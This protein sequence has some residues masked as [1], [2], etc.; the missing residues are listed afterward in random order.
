MEFEGGQESVALDGDVQRWEVRRAISRLKNGK[1]AG[2]DGVVAE[3]LRRGG[4][5]MGESVWWLCWLVFRGEKVPVEWLRAVKVPVRKKGSGTDFEHYRGVTLLSVVGKVFGMVVEA[6]LRAFCESRGILSDAQFGF[7]AGRACRDALMVL[8]EVVERRGGERVFAGF[9]DIAKAYPS[10]WRNGLW[11]K[12][13]EVGVRG[14]MWR[15]LRTLYSKCE[16]AVRVG[17][18]ADDWYEEFVGVREGCVVSP[19][20]FA[21][22]I[23]GLPALLDEGGG[24]SVKVGGTVIR[25]LM[26]ADDVVMLASTAAGLQRSFDIA[27][28]FGWRWRFKFNFGQDKSAVMVFGGVRDGERWVL[29]GREVPVVVTYRYLGVRLVTGRRGKWN[30]RRKELLVK[31]RGAFWRAWGLGMAGGWLSAKGAKGLWETLVLSVLE[32]GAEVD[33]G[34]WEEAEVLQRWAGRMCLGVGREVPNEV[35]MGDLGW[36]TVRGRREYL[37]LTYWGKVVREMKGNMVRAV[38]E[39]GRKR[40]EAGTAGKGEWCVE[41]ARLLREMGMGEE[42]DS[43]KVG[44][45]AGWRVMVRGMVQGRE[46]D[47]WR[48][49]MATKV[50]LEGYSKVKLQLRAEWFLGEGRCWV[51]RWVRVRA[52]ASCLEVVAGRRRGVARDKRVCGWCEVVEDE[53]HFLDVCKRWGSA[54]RQMWESLRLWDEKAVKTVAGWGSQARV[55]WLLA[56]G[57]PKMRHMVVKLVGGWMAQREKVG[58]GR[59]GS[60]GWGEQLSDITRERVREVQVGR[61]VERVT[62]AQRTAVVGARAAAISAGQEVAMAQRAAVAGARAAALAVGCGLE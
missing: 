26:F 57:S 17:S 16:V 55:D 31:A 2:V 35:V 30:E 52:G 37:R 62:M 1:A 19:L 24:G 6:R 45:E 59:L 47:R 13:L 56:G 8:T 42:W 28:R 15:V 14:R 60:G 12:L 29:E 36:W 49:A 39:E 32:Y 50:T 20:L 22:Y 5:W 18:V 44:G 3:V 53:R 40:M 43:E 51:R 21:I 34:R 23:N 4:D 25:C 9:L 54:R 7:R 58:C 46:E 41:T 38:Y 10:V 61:V 48:A 27:G 11:F 33:S